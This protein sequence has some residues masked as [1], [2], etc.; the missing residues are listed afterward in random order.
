MTKKLNQVL[1]IEKSLKGR[2]ETVIATNAAAAQKAELLNGFTKTFQPLKEG[3]VFVPP[4]SKK[5]QHSSK[6]IFGAI[7]KVLAELITTTASKDIANCT[8]RA[9]V[10]VRGAV[11]LKSVPSTNLLFLDKQLAALNS[12]VSRFSELESDTNWVY[13]ANT[14]YFR[15]EDIKTSV[16]QKVQEPLLMAAATPE[17][18]AQTTLITR[19]VLVGH[20]TTTKL[21]GALPRPV[22]SELL[23]KIQELQNA[24]KEALEEANG[25]AAGD[26]DYGKKIMDHLF[27]GVV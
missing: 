14:G 12:F 15:S 25:V 27:G 18:P 26:N 24:V 23:D 21:S 3:D 4:Q 5:V 9:D 6:E 1:A 2:A 22:K 10:W 13:D 7:T 8:A 20:W 11:L 19:D 16:T 17:H